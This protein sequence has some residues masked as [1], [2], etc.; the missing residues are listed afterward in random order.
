MVAAGP[1]NIVDELIRLAGGRNTAGGE[2]A[3][4]PTINAEKLLLLNPEIIILG[5]ERYLNNPGKVAETVSRWRNDSVWRNI[6]AVE[7]GRVYFVRTE[8]IGQPTPRNIEGLRKMLEIF[9]LK[10]NVEDRM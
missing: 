4:W 2:R 9:Q 1:D 8:L 3:K 5:E 7:A 10:K 6:A